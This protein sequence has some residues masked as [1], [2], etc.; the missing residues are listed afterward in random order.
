MVKIILSCLE[1]ILPVVGETETA[2]K[3]KSKTKRT[4]FTFEVE[5]ARPKKY[6]FLEENWLKTNFKTR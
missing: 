6:F 5:S 2:S 3:N 1:I 4:V